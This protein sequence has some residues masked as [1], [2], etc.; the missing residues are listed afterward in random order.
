MIEPAALLDCLRGNSGFMRNH[1]CAILP[2]VLTLGSLLLSSCYTA[3]PLTF[4]PRKGDEIVVAGQLF[5]TGT[6]VI[7]WMDPHGYDAYRV[8]R[9][10]SDLE[11][12]SFEKT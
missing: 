3:R 6:R 9:R 7:T 10:F 2:F 8:E 4:T 5:H 12:S 11:E 1:P